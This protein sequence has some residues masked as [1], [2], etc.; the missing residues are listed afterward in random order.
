MGFERARVGSVQGGFFLF[1]FFFLLRGFGFSVKKRGTCSALDDDVVAFFVPKPL[2]LRKQPEQTETDP[3]I[4]PIN[5]N[6]T[7]PGD[8]TSGSPSPAQKRRRLFSPTPLPVVD[9][10]KTRE[11]N[12]DTCLCFAFFFYTQRNPQIKQRWYFKKNAQQ[13]A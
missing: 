1:F 7:F 9:A 12:A 3:S 4:S 2:L 8:L 10:L 13:S 11:I 5:D 6:I